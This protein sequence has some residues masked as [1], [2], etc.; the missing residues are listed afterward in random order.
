MSH[1]ILPHKANFTE[2]P[3]SEE[4]IP[5][6][7]KWVISSNHTVNEIQTSLK[8]FYSTIKNETVKTFAAGLFSIVKVYGFAEACCAIGLVPIVSGPTD[9]FLLL[10]P[11][12]S[13]DAS[14]IDRF[15]NDSYRSLLLFFAGMTDISSSGDA[16]FVSYAEKIDVGGALG[17]NLFRLPTG[18]ILF[19]VPSTGAV[20]QQCDQVVSKH[21]NSLEECLEWYL[22]TFR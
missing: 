2:F 15:V 13:L 18:D 6:K 20:W 21:S 12:V 22:S 14:I 7:W 8:L 10:N 16:A 9:R 19:Y 3:L 4:K 17:F 11:P 5:D 1:F